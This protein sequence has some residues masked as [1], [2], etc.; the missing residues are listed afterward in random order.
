MWRPWSSYA[1]IIRKAA[2]LGQIPK[3][4]ESEHYEKRYHHYDILIVGAGPSG[5]A[6]ALVAGES[7]ARVLIVDDQ[8]QPGGRLL[9]EPAQIDGQSA[10]N[11]VQH[12]TAEVDRMPKIR[13]LVNS[14][15]AGDY[16][17]NMLMNVERNPEQS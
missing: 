16:V 6:A 10:V 13:R 15:V 1:R 7:G 17:H 12:V 2:G 11:W 9:S 3:T 8:S 14:T 4:T 5:L